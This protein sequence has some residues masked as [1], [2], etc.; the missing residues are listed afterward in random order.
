MEK[1]RRAEP[2]SGLNPAAAAIT[3]SRVDLPEPFS[4]AKKVTGRAESAGFPNARAAGK[5]VREA[6][7]PAKIPSVSSTLRIYIKLPPLGGRL[8]HL[9]VYHD[10]RGGY[11]RPGAAT[12]RERRCVFFTLFS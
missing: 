10:L 8:C 4:P 6:S 3:S 1:R 11:K 7:P 5:E 2:P 9:T 12:I